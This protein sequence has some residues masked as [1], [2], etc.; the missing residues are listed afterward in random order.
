MYIRMLSEY[1]CSTLTD[2]RVCTYLH[3]RLSVCVCL[4]ACV[5]VK[6]QRKQLLLLHS[7]DTATDIED[8]SDTV[9]WLLVGAVTYTH[10]H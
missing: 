1:A 9:S 6:F 5:Q 4:C 10:P 7:S 8:Y 3:V 2:M